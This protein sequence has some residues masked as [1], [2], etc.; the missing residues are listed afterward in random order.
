MSEDQ[1]DK[2]EDGS[3]REGTY[4]ACCFE[5]LIGS[6]SFSMPG[7]EWVAGL[8]IGRQGDQKLQAF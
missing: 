1:K 2:D 4:L 5:C 6:L 8:E 3:A 7:I